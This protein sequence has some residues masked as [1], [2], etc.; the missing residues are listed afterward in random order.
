LKPDDAAWK[1][2]LYVL[3]SAASKSKDYSYLMKRLRSA[4]DDLLKK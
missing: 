4:I 1:Q 2:V 3:M